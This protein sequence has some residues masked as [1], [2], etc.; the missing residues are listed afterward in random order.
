MKS[1]VASK[2]QYGPQRPQGDEG[3]GRHQS[4]LVHSCLVVSAFTA[5]ALTEVRAL[6]N[7]VLVRT[8]IG[9]T[10]NSDTS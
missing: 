3:P 6:P 7:Q 5:V 2:R 8:E 4:K 9:F 10:R 1:N